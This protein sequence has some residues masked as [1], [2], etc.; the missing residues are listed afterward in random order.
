MAPSA[1]GHE[2]NKD[3][4]RVE[5][6]NVRGTIDRDRVDLEVDRESFDE[7]GNLVQQEVGR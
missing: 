5:N 1:A 7:S 3:A 2:S 4:T 6:P